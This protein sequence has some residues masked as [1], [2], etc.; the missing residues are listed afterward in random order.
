MERPMPV[1]APAK[2]TKEVKTEVKR[3]LKT[4]AADHLKN[5]IEKGGSGYHHH[6]AQETGAEHPSAGLGNAEAP[7][8]PPSFEHPIMT[9]QEFLAGNY[10]EPG[11]VVVMT[12]LGSFFAWLLKAFN[13]S[14]FAHAAMVFQTPQ[15]MDGLEQTFLIETSMGG[16][17]IVSLSQFLMPK[18]VYADTG[19]PPDFVVGIRRLEK[20]WV[21][22]RHRRIAAS[23]M[24]HFIENHEYNFRLLAALASPRTRTLY[25]RVVN[26]LKRK[27]PALS[28]FLK[29][30]GSYVPNNFICS[31]FVQYAY[32]NMIAAAAKKGIMSA[33][34][35]DLALEDVLFMPNAT[36]TSKIEELL[37]CTPKFLAETDKLTWKYLIH[38]GDVFH[39]SSNEEVNRFFKETLPKRAPEAILA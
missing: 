14:D 3:H 5:H 4:S 22:V 25:F 18:H 27:A 30:G 36:I 28:E 10:V 33:D 16:V 2:S 21:G 9:V 26:S 19:L 24:L 1:T 37:A 12:R 35:V 34:Q 17:E 31:G 23:R 13:N 38:H 7:P 29:G 15:H 8:A 39:V 6:P 11:D 20:H 32:V